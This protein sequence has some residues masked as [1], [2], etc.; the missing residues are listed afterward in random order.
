[1]CGKSH[2]DRDW[3]KI[4]TG[5][6]QPLAVGRATRKFWLTSSTPPVQLDDERASPSNIVRSS[7]MCPGSLPVLSLDQKAQFRDPVH[8][9]GRSGK[10][11]IFG[12]L[13]SGR[14][15]HVLLVDRGSI[16]TPSRTIWRPPDRRA[17]NRAE[18]FGR[19]TGSGTTGA[20]APRRCLILGGEQF[21]AALLNGS[22]RSTPDC[23]IINRLR[24][25][26]I[27]D[28]SAHPSN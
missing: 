6:H 13:C 16:L 10:T 1:M 9:R 24:T 12:S 3:E 23:E 21:I 20:G 4:S 22:E 7:I 19:P 14:M 11:S 28:R 27:D 25:H 15:L 26:G 2:L 5:A 8:G 17:E 18:S